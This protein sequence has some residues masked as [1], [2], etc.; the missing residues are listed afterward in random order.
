MRPGSGPSGNKWPGVGDGSRAPLTLL[1][2]EVKVGDRAPDFRVLDGTLKVATL[3]AFR[4]KLKIISS[5]P[6]LIS[7]VCDAETHRFNE[8]AGKLPENV[9]VLTISM[10]L[11]FAQTRWCAAAGVEKGEDLLRL[12][13]LLLRRGLRGPDQ[14]NWSACPGGVPGGRLKH[15]PVC[16]VSSRTHQRARLRADSKHGPGSFIKSSV[17]EIRGRRA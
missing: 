6:S 10:D 4:G 17:G 8:E 13:G 1:G 5:V 11:P 9:A 7:L 3:D 15:R 16:R 2:A 12:P 14:R